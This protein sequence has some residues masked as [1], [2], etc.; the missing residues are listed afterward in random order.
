MSFLLLK[1]T[2]MKMFRWLKGLFTLRGKALKLYRRGMARAKG[3]DQFGAIDDYTATIDMLGAPLDVV[4]M[5]LFNRSLVFVATGENSKATCDLDA[6]AAMCKAPAR[7]KAMARQQLIR[8]RARALKQLAGETVA[9]KRQNG[10]IPRGQAIY[11]QSG[12]FGIIS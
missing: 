7:V 8:M 6:V 12:Q 11:G 5:A 1:A 3:N 9:N 4:A 2:Q 10:D